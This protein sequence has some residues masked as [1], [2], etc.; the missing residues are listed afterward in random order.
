MLSYWATLT[1]PLPVAVAVT[2]PGVPSTVP[3]VDAVIVPS[4]L[5]LVPVAAP[6]T[7]ALFSLIKNCRS[8]E[9]PPPGAG[10]ETG[11]SAVAA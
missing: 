3:P 8:L 11:T 2:L 5:L 9:V 7:P 1:E 4:G 10:V 6:V